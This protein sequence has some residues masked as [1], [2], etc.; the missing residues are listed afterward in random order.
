MALSPGQS[1]LHYELVEKIGE[2]GMGRVW[3]AM[4]TRLGREVAIKF[5]A[6]ELEADP[7]WLARFVYEARTVAALNHPNIVTIHASEEIGGRRFLVME[8]VRGTTLDRVIPAGGLPVDRFYELGL[9]ILDAVGAAHE[10]GV[11]HRDLKPHNIMVDEEGRPKVLDFGLARSTLPAAAAP[12]DSGDP[13]QPSLF[14]GSVEGTLRYMAPEM[15]R[16]ELADFRSDIFSLGVVLFEMATGKPP[17]TGA[18]ASEL[19][20]SILR[21]EPRLPSSL[22]PG[23]AG[24]LD[25]VLPRALQKDPSRRFTSAEEFH[26]ALH[27]ARLAPADETARPIRSI[28]VL[29]LDDFSGDPEQAF[30]SDGMTDV[31]INNLARIRALKVISRASVMQYRNAKKPL[32]TTAAELGVD[33]VVEGSVVRAGG[34]VRIT[35]RLIDAVHDRLLWADDYERDLGDVLALQSEVARSIAASIELELTPQEHAQIDHAGRPVD[36]AVHEAYLMGRYFW[37]KRTSESVRRGL[38]CFEEAVSLDPAYAPAHV[39]IADSYIVDGGRYLDVPPKIAY[40][41]ARSAALQALRLDDNLAEAHTSLAAVLTDYEWDWIGSDREYR[42]AL[43]LNPNYA[44]AHSWYAEQLSRMGRHDEAI[45]EAQR[46]LELDPVSIFSSMLVAWIL[47]FA[48][49]YD[50]AIAQAN[51]TLELDADYATALRILGWAL[52]ETRRYSEAIAAHRRACALTGQR[53]NFTAQLARACAVAGMAAEAR[54][55]LAELGATAKESYVSA[56]DFALIHA[57]LG[58]TATALDWLERAFEEHSDHL[59]YIRVNP[60]LDP[61]RGEPRFQELLR[62][63]GLETDPTS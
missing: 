43:E 35:A 62:R 33:A 19:I 12:V 56:F 22:R 24:G 50:E 16:G 17:F 34:R 41:R 30:F 40:A 11:T 63:M 10:R 6:E 31:L 36:P 58:E 7:Q 29:P 60:R 8:L 54:Q 42:R 2:G 57:A 49:R 38:R 44:T 21:D 48:R 4:D 37:Y 26:G 53:P 51:K 25:Q 28:A 32:A 61:L 46:A 9:A 1:L 3:R 55:I 13:T 5:L 18:T 15:L 20:A 27:A 39:G 14:F 59:P 52:E 23:L 45:A 47:Y